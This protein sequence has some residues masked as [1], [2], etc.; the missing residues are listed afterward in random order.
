MPKE[1]KSI[2]F[3]EKFGLWIKTNLLL[4]IVTKEGCTIVG[5]M[6]NYLEKEKM[7]LVYDVD[8]KNVFNIHLSE[9]SQIQPCK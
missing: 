9:I 6:L 2:L 3:R 1:E 7:I 4:E 8:H 5:R